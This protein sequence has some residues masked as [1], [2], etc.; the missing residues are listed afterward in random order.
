MKKNEGYLKDYALLCREA[1]QLEPELFDKYEVQRG[2]RDKN[3]NGVVTGLTNISRIDS[4]K[5]VDGKKMPC[6]GRLWYRGYDCIELVKGFRRK[7]FGFE[8]AGYLLLFGKLPNERQLKEFRDI[9]A[10][11][12][13][14]PTNFTRDVIMKA[15]SSDIMNS[16]TRSVLTL[17]SYDKNC[18]DTS[19][20]NVL[21]QCIALISVFPMLSVYGY[22]AY[23]H[24]QNDESMYIHRPSRKLST[25]ENLLMMLRPDK[26]YTEL[27]AR[28]LDIALVL[29]MEH[30]G[31][32][33]STFTTRVVTSSGSDTYSV[34]A[35]ALSSLKGPKHGGANIK[36]VEMMRE[37]GEKVSDW[38]DEDAVR[39]YLKKI[40]NKEAFDH[41]GLIYGMGHAVYSLS[42]PRAQVFKGFVEQLAE[43]KG[44]NRDFAL[45]SMIERLAP[46]V[47]AEKARIYKGVSANVDFYSGFVY[48]MLEIPLEM[49]TPIF[50][51]ARIVGWSAH[52]I[53]ELINMDKIIRPAYKSVMEEKEYVDIAHR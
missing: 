22:H 3:G 31:G 25:A 40:L 18:S 13:T 15:P 14:L 37:I 7:Q 2:L 45:Y 50:A 16:L 20:E 26:Q 34:I 5:V 10:S 11:N 49:Y 39:D 24:Y 43:A 21:R 35:A 33:N 17:A 29:H 4:F 28:V 30:G 51:I 36:V 23:N 46:Q 32:N 42:D 44:R 27:E 1:D 9:L 47:I 41:K 12:R 19:I 8:E 52:R 38:E 6:E 48:S 53:E